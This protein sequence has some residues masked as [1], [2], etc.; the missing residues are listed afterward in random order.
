MESD[1]RK[2]SEMLPRLRER[3][4]AEQNARIVGA[5]TDP[6][7]TET[8]RFWDSLEMM[9]KEAKILHQCLDGYSRSKMWLFMLCMLRVGM[10]KKEDLSQFSE[11]L[12]RELA[13][14]IPQEQG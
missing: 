5:L 2:F 12:Q 8:E 1:W 6:R 3:Y 9:K 4:L 10:L 11:E 13:R 7:K 14:D